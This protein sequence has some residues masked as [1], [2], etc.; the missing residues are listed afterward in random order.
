[1]AEYHRPGMT[2]GGPHDPFYNTDHVLISP[3]QG[4]GKGPP[5]K[6]RVSVSE[7]IL[8][9]LQQKGVSQKT[10]RGKRRPLPVNNR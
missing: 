9:Q 2:V 5:P 10:R 1:M 3:P 6:A 7:A 4:L 8:K